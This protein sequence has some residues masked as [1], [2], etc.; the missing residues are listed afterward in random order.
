MWLRGTGGMNSEE[1]SL[2]KETE[3]VFGAL[4]SVGDCAEIF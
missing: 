2:E 1:M 4:P 3:G